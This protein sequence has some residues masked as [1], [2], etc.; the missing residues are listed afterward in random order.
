MRTAE[1]GG[2]IRP[3][4]VCD[5]EFCTSA[6]AVALMVD[7]INRCHYEFI[8]VTPTGNEDGFL[9]FFRRIAGD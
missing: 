3:R 9:V 8:C 4:M 7:E 1:N 2:P 6:A 5:Y